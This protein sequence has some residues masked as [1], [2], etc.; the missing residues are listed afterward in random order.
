MLKN[1]LSQNSYWVINKTMT[2]RIGLEIT[3]LLSDLI[4]KEEYFEKKNQLVEDEWFFNTSENIEE[5]TTLSYHKQRIHIKKL[6]ELGFIETKRMGLPAKQYFK[7]SKDIILLFLKQDLKEF[8]NLSLKNLRTCPEEIQELYNNNKINNNKIIIKKIIIKKISPSQFNSFW[9][10]YP[11]K[12]GKGQAL[13]TWNKICKKPNKDKPTWREIKL[14]IRNQIKSDQWLAGQI[15]NPSTWLNES[16]WL[17]DAKM[18][19]PFI[20]EK[21][22]RGNRTGLQGTDFTNVDKVES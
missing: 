15:A 8:K 5:D 13:T 20:K 4:T 9:K 7:I 11:K 19:K 14:A 18:M 1:I 17:N 16:R 22:Q 21:V 2:K 12:A 3:L 10:T 6:E